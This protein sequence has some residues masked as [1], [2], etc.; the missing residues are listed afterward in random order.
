[1]NTY[2]RGSYKSANDTITLPQELEALHTEP[3][4][5]QNELNNQTLHYPFS[6]YLFTIPQKKREFKTKEIIT[7][8]K[9]I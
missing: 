9:S 4:N 5:K 3:V 2:I 6:Y 7:P 1:M 8:A